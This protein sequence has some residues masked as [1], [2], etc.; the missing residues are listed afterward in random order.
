M[1]YKWTVL[2]VTTV[3]VLM[4][5]IDGRIVVIGLPQVA[6]ALGADAE[7]AIW[8]TQSYVLGS[9]IALLFIGRVTDI[10]GRVKVY[11]LG[12]T[13]FTIGS[14]LTSLSQ[15]PDH[16]VVF[17]MVQ[18]LGSAVLF[19]NS[20]ALITD[21]T[22]V[23]E[24]GLSLGINQVAYR[25]GS[26]L[27]LTFSGLVLTYLDWR[28]LFYVNVPIGIFGTFWA[29]RRLREIATLERGAPMDWEGF[30]TFTA[31]ISFFLLALTFAAYGSA[32]YPVVESLI[33]VSFIALAAF[34]L[35]ERRT[36]SPLLDLS[37]LGI[38][39]FTGGVVAQL[40]NAVSWGAVLLLL[41]IY[42]QLIRGLPPFQAGLA[43]LPFDL[44]FLAVGPISG[45]LS[46]RFGHVP[47]TTAGLSL[48][49]L[50]L[51][52]LS[53]TNAFTPYLQIAV[54]FII[55]G[56]GI[57]LFSSPNI[58]SIL[59]AGPPQRRGIA[60]GFR[61]TFFFVGF[62]LSFNLAILVMT[63]SVPYSVITAVI[64]SF[65]SPAIGVPEKVLFT[66]ALSRAYQWFA[67]LNA[68]AIVPSLL[69]GKRD[70]AATS[71]GSSSIPSNELSAPSTE[72][73][74]S[75]L[76]FSLRPSALRNLTGML[77]GKTRRRNR[78]NPR[79]FRPESRRKKR[80]RQSFRST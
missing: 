67:V 42:L 75:V 40:L 73:S 61:A 60:S 56:A 68:T 1:E 14:A 48:M 9:T 69:R 38:R 62:T 76:P 47:F 8:F 36:K 13:V 5:G 29:H 63:L 4:A 10:F 26:M 80:W 21:A 22:P 77:I 19:T 79:I 58:R 51:Y 15:V 11:T 34:L 23:N 55:F 6:A 74:S 50:S 46:D 28:A 41:S 12:F 72:R 33:A 37:L 57:G 20:A 18:G 66:T 2:T 71:R 17:R 43:L 44:S 65:N 45:R 54:D 32:E 49:S 25:L 52:L 39:E 31:S 3:G 30:A 35:L 27:G 16:V 53:M 70:A 78:F 59:G 7:Q 64:T 24:L